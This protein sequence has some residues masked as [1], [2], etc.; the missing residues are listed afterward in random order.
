MFVTRSRH[1]WS[2]ALIVL[3]LTNRRSRHRP[4][5]ECS[6]KNYLVTKKNLHNFKVKCTGLEMH[7]I[8]FNFFLNYYYNN[9]NNHNFFAQLF[10]SHLLLFVPVLPKKDTSIYSKW[11]NRP[12]KHLIVSHW[13]LQTHIQFQYLI[14]LIGFIRMRSVL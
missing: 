1:H 14:I 3:V 7:I 6:V 10:A 11:K 13:W 9:S 5:S 2:T 4:I 8:S 12:F